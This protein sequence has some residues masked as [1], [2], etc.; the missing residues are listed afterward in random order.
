MYLEQQK[1]KQ[2]WENRL[3]YGNYVDGYNLID[4]NNNTCQ[5]DFETS[6]VFFYN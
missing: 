6:R 5:M 1:P 2:L 3:V 4:S